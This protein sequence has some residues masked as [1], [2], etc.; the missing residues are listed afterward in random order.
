MISKDMKKEMRKI[1]GVSIF[2]V[3]R[4]QK[5]EGKSTEMK[6]IQ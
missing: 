2:K 1:R 6:N 4:G 5:N 3:D